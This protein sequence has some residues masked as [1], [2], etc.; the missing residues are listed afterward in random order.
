MSL[1]RT[2]AGDLLK[3]CAPSRD[4]P[5]VPD[6]SASGEPAFS[7]YHEKW[8]LDL[9]TDGSWD[10]S[11]ITENGVV[12]GRMPYVVERWLGLK[13]SRLPSLVRTLGP[14]ITPAA[15]ATGPRLARRI[16]IAAALIRQ[17]PR[18]E[19]F[20]QLFDPRIEE[21]SAF[22]QLGFAVGHAYTFQIPP[23]RSEDD[24]WEGVTFKT[25]N[26]IRKAAKTLTVSRS[27]DPDEFCRFYNENLGTEPNYHGAARMRRLIQIILEREAG[28]LMGTRT[29][30]GTLAAA[31]CI[32]WDHAAARYLLATRR[33][34]LAGGGAT[35]LLI[36]EAIRLACA[37]G[38]GFDFDGITSSAMLEFLAAFGGELAK[39]LRVRRASR[40]YIL[41]QAGLSA[42]RTSSLAFPDRAGL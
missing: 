5:K 19:L 14:V 20:D 33:P 42:F 23:G 22:T 15:D 3:E 25:R 29:A 32:V 8:W 10:E 13:L 35:M 18:F 40:Q 41:A 24:I 28:T 39:R 36:W 9:V 16:E 38:I 21:A 4:R 12:I 7:I 31:V 30:D 17:L 1:A 2:S 26:H 6:A 37:R 27:L 11:V 34:D